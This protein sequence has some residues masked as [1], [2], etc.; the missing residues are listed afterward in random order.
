MMKYLISEIKRKTHNGPIH[1]D[2][3]LDVSEIETRNSDIRKINPVHVVGD[4]TMQ[5]DQII[6]SFL[7]SG[8]MILPC[9]RTLVDVAYPFEIKA[10]EIFSSSAKFGET[11]QEN[12]IHAIDEEMLDL[13][14]YIKENILLEVPFRVFS[15][16]AMERENISMKGNGW[17]F[18]TEEKEKETIDP[19]FKK[20]ES[21]LD[22]KRKIEENN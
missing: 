13:T 10:Q 20:L 4:C 15:E 8:E 6:F 14:P 3:W 18:I 22:K 17:E 16:D 2:E 9:A 21:L 7:I 12:E 11:G 19:R 1:F 5:G